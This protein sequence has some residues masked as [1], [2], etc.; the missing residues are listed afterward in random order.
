MQLNFAA[1]DKAAK[2]ANYLLLFN[3]I[4]YSTYSIPFCERDWTCEGSC[5]YFLKTTEENNLI[6]AS[7]KHVKTLVKREK[8]Y[9]EN[10]LELDYS[11]IER[12]CN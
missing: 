1:A 7:A 11:I 4:L 2:Y 3:N 8:R 6:Y 5:L 10:A 12:L 9:V